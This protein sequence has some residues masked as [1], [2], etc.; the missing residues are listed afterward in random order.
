MSEI[1]DCQHCWHV[2]SMYHATD[3]EH[4][5][6]VCCHCAVSKHEHILCDSYIY[7]HEPLKHGPFAPET[8]VRYMSESDVEPSDVSI[9]AATSN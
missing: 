8:V 4:R 1:R 9:H 6:Y 3:G 2:T 5:N 7:T